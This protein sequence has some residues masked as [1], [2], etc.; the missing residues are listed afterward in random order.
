MLYYGEGAKTG[1][2]V[3]FANSDSVMLQIFLKFLIDICGINKQKLR[4]YLYC[5]SDQNTHELIRFWCKTLKVKKSYFTKPYI[6]K[7]SKSLRRTMQHGVLHIR[8]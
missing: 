6:R 7:A 8:Y 2:T 4:F 5:F 1:K 3:D